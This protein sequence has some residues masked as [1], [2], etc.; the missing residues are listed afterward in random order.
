MTVACAHSRSF[1]CWEQNYAEVEA[2]TDPESEA[3][4]ICPQA[5]QIP[6]QI[7]R[8]IFSRIMRKVPPGPKMRLL[9]THISAQRRRA[10]HH[11][12]FTRTSTYQ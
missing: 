7:I 10:W 8:T 4:R 3:L 6:P 9:F 2:N 12:H 11:V 1:L 5:L